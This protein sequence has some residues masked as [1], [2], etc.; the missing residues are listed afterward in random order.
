MASKRLFK[1]GQEIFA[2]LEVRQTNSRENPFKE[3]SS[4]RK[5]VG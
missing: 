2:D 1:I 5:N 4:T 3:N